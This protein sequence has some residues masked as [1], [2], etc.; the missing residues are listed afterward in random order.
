M[1]APTILNTTFSTIS[2]DQAI[3]KASKVFPK[4]EGVKIVKIKSATTDSPRPLK[5]APVRRRSC[6]IEDPPYFVPIIR[7][8][9]K[10]TPEITVDGKRYGAGAGTATKTT[11]QTIPIRV[12]L[13]LLRVE[14]ISADM[15]M[16]RRKCSG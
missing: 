8:R 11:P 4:V 3:A 15:R 10:I 7:A 1:N 13:H 2:A 16:P 9:S 12:A 14:R 6:E 5:P